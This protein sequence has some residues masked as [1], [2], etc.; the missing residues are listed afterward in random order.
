MAPQ[1]HT[2]A[3]YAKSNGIELCYDTFGDPKAPPI[4]LIM[5]LAA[6]MIAWDEEFCA[7]LAAQAVEPISRHKPVLRN[8]LFSIRSFPECYARRYP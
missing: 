2:A 6:Q 1:R 5:G 7:Q 8:H 4:V 3:A